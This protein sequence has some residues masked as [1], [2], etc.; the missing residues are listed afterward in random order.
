MVIMCSSVSIADESP[1]FDGMTVLEVY[2]AGMTAYQQEDY[3]G[4]YDAMSELDIRRPYQLPVQYNFAIAHILIGDLD[5]AVARLDYVADLGLSIDL[6]ADS[7]FDPLKDH[8]GYQALQ[9]RFTSNAAPFG[10]SEL[11]FEFDSLDVLPEGLA[12]DERDGTIFI[13]TVRSGEIYRFRMDG[14]LEVFADG[15][16]HEG[17]GGI[18]GMAVDAARGVLWATSSTPALYRG[19]NHGAETGS[20]LYAFDLST[21]EVRHAF[22]IS[23]EGAFLG[24]VLVA[25][26]GDVYASDSMVPRL[27]RF[28]DGMSEPEEI[29]LEGTTTNLQGFDFAPDGRIYLADYQA[30]LFVLNRDGTDIVKLMMPESV[31]PSGIDGMF[32]REGALI[33]IQNAT[34]PHRIVR[35]ELSSD[36]NAISDFEVLVSNHDLWDEPTLG[37]IVDGRLFYIATAEWPDYGADGERHEGSEMHPIR[38]MSVDL[39]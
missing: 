31:N 10:E 3:T 28:S 37:Q 6:P 26:S 22:E 21:G 35:Y 27:F 33:G 20:H 7:D 9:A 25:P 17:M 30:G 2:G 29:S 34:Q 16:V 12:I 38:I 11:A 4:F 24:E 1:A 23:G 13:S 14:E 18:F 39:D 15:D 32:Y 8:P 19:A 5:G 36:G